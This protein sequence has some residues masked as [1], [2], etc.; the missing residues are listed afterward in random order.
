M[1]KQEKSEHNNIIVFL[2]ILRID[3]VTESDLKKA[4]VR[5][6]FE[7]FGRSVLKIDEKCSVAASRINLKSRPVK[8]QRTTDGFMVWK[9]L[10]SWLRRTAEEV[11][12]FSN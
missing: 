9:Y 8:V 2:I 11:R 5:V 4:V 3:L 1:K 6:P 7:F 12:R 10:D